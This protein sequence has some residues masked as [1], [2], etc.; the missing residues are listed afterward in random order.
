MLDNL[1]GGK[2]LRTVSNRFF[3]DSHCNDIL[4]MPSS[5][6]TTREMIEM[7]RTCFNVDSADVF[8]APKF[9]SAL[10]KGSQTVLNGIWLAVEAHEV[11][12][13]IIFRNQGH[14]DGKI[15]FDQCVR[16]EEDKAR[17]QGMMRAREK[18]LSLHPGVKVLLIYG[19]FL[20]CG[21][22]ILLSE[23]HPDFSETVRLLAENR[24]MDELGN[25]IP[26]EATVITCMDYRQIQEVRDCVRYDFKIDRFGLIGLPGSGKRFIEDGIISWNSFY[27]AV[28]KHGSNLFFIFHHADCGAY[29]G[30]D[31]FNCDPIAE[32]LMHRAQMYHLR[33]MIYKRK[34]GVKVI[35]VYVRFIEGKRRIRFVC[36]D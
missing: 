29:G 5:H 22:Q 36:F 25:E 2:V 19:R 20:N 12:R 28:E 18:I 1:I 11:G 23:I 32:E 33:D 14:D 4:I 27:E 21:K 13:I 26:C 10:M 17:I 6:V 16:A 8:A 34:P 31:A 35:L 9:A 30:E 15:R 7:A 24:F 3:E